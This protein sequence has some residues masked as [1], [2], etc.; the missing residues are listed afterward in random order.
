MKLVYLCN[1]LHLQ[2]KKLRIYT[3]YSLPFRHARR[4]RASVIS[5]H[6]VGVLAR[7]KAYACMSCFKHDNGPREQNN[8]LFLNWQTDV[9]TRYLCKCNKLGVSPMTFL[10]TFRS[11][12]Y[13]SLYYL[14]LIDLIFWK[15]VIIMVHI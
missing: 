11:D 2:V 10:L 4:K 8:V 15:T 12:R 6:V 3:F 7:P 14:F 9:T 5:R 1:K 13:E